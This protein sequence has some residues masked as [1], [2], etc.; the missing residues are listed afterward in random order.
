M[1]GRPP[2]AQGLY[3]STRQVVACHRT[4][5]FI[6]VAGAAFLAIGHGAMALAAGLLASSLAS[7]G[8]AKRALLLAAIGVVAAAA[9]LGASVVTA[10]AETRLSGAVGTALRADV[11]AGLLARGSDRGGPADVARIAGAVRA[12]E[13]AVEG[14][15][16][17]SVRSAV[18]IVPLVGVLFLL[19]PAAAAVAVGVLTPFAIAL[20]RLRQTVRT[21]ED[22]ALRR[23]ASLD[24]QVDELV[25]HVDLWRTYGSGARV[26]RALVTAAARAIEASAVARERRAALSGAN[27]V[28]AALAL[29]AVL[30]V[31]SAGLVR[32]DGAAL[33]PFAAVFFLA[34]RPLRDLGDAVLAVR[35]GDVALAAVASFR[36]DEARDATPT[37]TPTSVLETLELAS[38]GA[39]RGDAEVSLSLAPGEIVALVGPTGAGKSSLLRA[40]LGLE[41]SRG[42]A[43]YGG[44]TLDA[45]VGLARP[46]AWMPQDAPI[47]AGTLDENLSL[48]ADPSAARETLGA[49]AG[50]SFAVALGDATLGASGRPLSG[51]ERAWVSL[52]RA[53]ATG[54]PVL[55]LDEPTASLDRDAEDR[56]LEVVARLRGARSVLLVTHRESTSRVADRVVRIGP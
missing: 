20:S 14:G 21:R 18:Q 26:Q 42:T 40:L 16:F 36:S 51:G 45:P 24:E 56:F 47:V 9:K 44:R 33:V 43:S 54:Q 46:F 34:Y 11:A 22:G 6:Y 28:L 52:A 10:G 49:L 35:S 2:R 38:F 5:A 4:I 41:T 53:I 27:E 15:V 37:E 31:T 23:A 30:A 29:V 19:S 32:I 1:N 7:G 12:V 3:A 55:L 39:E 17:A 48:A 8:G 50:Q 25:R 13:R